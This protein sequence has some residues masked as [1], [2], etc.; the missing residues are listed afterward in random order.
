MFARPSG[1]VRYLGLAL[2]MLCALYAFKNNAYDATVS[3]LHR[4]SG[5][6]G[7]SSAADR[8]HKGKNKAHPID[9]LIFD[10]QH[11]FTELLSKESKTVEDAAQAYRKRRGRHPPPGFAEWFEFAQSKGAIVIEDFFDQIH[12]DIE[13][14]WGVEPA[15]M[16]RESQHFDM[17]INVRNGNAT[18]GSDWFWTAIWLRMIKNVEHLLPDMD[19]PLNAMDEPRIIAP[20]EDIQHYM[21]KAAKTMGLAKPEKMISEF[22]SLPT[23]GNVDDGEMRNKEW[24]GAETNPFW[25]LVRRGCPPKS[26]ARTT[27]VQTDF[28]GTPAFNTSFA[29]PHSY[30]GYVSNST[31]S[32]DVCHQPDLQ[33]LAGVFI[34]PLSTSTTKVLFP[35]FGGSKLAVNNEILI[36]AAMYYEGEKRFTGG[37]DHG[38]EWSEKSHNVIW[39]GVG[40]GGRN[41]DN[42]WKGFQ[43]HRFVAMN[44]ATTVKRA[45][46]GGAQDQPENFVLPDASYNVAAQ[47]DGRLGEW[48][49]NL[50]NVGLT[51]LSCT[52]A[53]GDLRCAYMDHAYD[54]VKGVDLTEQ[55]NSKILPDIDG[56]SFSGRYIGF[57]RS[58][59]LPIKST[60]WR[61]WHDSRLV[62]WKHFVPMDNRFTDYYGIL[63]YFLGYEGRGA[64][65][66]AAEKIATEGKDWAERVLRKEDMEIY[67]LRLLLEYGRLLDDRRESMGWVGDVLAKPSLMRKWRQW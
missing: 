60:V 47:K 17:T 20:Y 14:F 38:V 56:N 46:S 66:D 30:Q 21:T 29:K 52:P 5:F 7:L 49:G 67:V 23:G 13:P 12:H 53:Q 27:P 34:E 65:D 37:D 62:A 19:I 39:R 41:R 16:R 45:E 58:T 57:L 9:S 51:D 10:A 55:F 54:T 31:L 50:T 36:P 64:H 6:G 3:N 42:T 59:S 43:R 48:L 2:I 61:E 35:L 15:L 22:Q 18:A 1:I 40:T 32:R 44:N 24:E 28:A 8:L 26:L 25:N 11:K 33:G 4:P 63:D